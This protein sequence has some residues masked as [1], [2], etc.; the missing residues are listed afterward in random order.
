MEVALTGA[1][2]VIEYLGSTF[3]SLFYLN[4]S[5]NNHSRTLICLIQ[6]WEMKGIYSM[7][8]NYGLQT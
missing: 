7:S 2:W 8:I 6:L 3:E 5:F 4:V 1:S